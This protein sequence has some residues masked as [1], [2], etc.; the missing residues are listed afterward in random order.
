MRN[1]KALVFISALLIFNSCGKDFEN[2]MNAANEISSYC[3]TKDVNVSETSMSHFNGK[4]ISTY[5]ITIKNVKQLEEGGYPT[6]LVASHCAKLLYEK[7]T[8]EQRNEKEAINVKIVKAAG[9]EEFTYE[10]TQIKKIDAFAKIAREAILKI[11][12]KNYAGI[13]DTNIDKS[14]ITQDVFTANLV[15]KVLQPN[16]EIFGKI[17]SIEIV[18]FDFRKENNYDL[19]DIYVATPTEKNRVNFQFTFKNQKNPKVAGIWINLN[20]TQKD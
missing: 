8:D 6:M 3:G 5:N 7:L 10:I 1:L 13:Y 9:A 12:G 16:E 11:K 18:G 19:V 14:A 4:N 17:T 2:L 20:P 15:D